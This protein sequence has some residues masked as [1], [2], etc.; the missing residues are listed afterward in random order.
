MLSRLRSAG[1]LAAVAGLLAGA[2]NAFYLWILWQ[3]GEG[4]L[5]EANVRYVAASVAAAAI[6]LVLAGR[7]RSPSVRAAALAASAAAL[8]GFA[9]LASLTIGVLLLPAVALAWLAV[10]REHE[11]AQER[12]HPRAAAA[13]VAIGLVIP[14]VFLLIALR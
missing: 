9:L 14:L 12:P 7:L 2:W 8:S 11:P 6:V 10:G 13:G 5:A 1:S 3:E 4:D